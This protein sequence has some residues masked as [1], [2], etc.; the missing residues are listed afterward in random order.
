MGMNIHG[1]KLITGLAAA[2]LGTA[3][4]GFGS[5][6]FHKSN[7][8]AV[9]ITLLNTTKFH[10]GESLPAGTYRMEVPENSATPKVTFFKDGKAMATVDAKVVN[11]E[12][13]NQNTEVNAVTQGDQQVVTSIEPGGWH[14]KLQFDSNGM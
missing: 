3:C 2:V 7:D 9:D 8:R 5:W 13:K 1:N 11:E 14:E 4:L 12:Q 6:G 10:N